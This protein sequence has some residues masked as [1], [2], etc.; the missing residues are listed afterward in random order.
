MPAGIERRHGQAPQTVLNVPL[1][2]PAYLVSHGGAAFPDLV[3]VLQGE[4][5]KIV[6]DGKTDIKKGITYSRFETVP[7]APISSFE[8]T[9][10]RV[11]TR[12]SQP[13]PTTFARGPGPYSSQSACPDA[14]TGEW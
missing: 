13:S 6:L 3:F 10:P 1:S 12:S 4:G 5:V 14:S 7:D 9:L 2:G 11:R 8:A